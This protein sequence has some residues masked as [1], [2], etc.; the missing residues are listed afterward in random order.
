MSAA[1][2]SGSTMTPGPTPTPTPTP[3]PAPEPVMESTHETPHSENLGMAVGLPISACM[4]LIF[5]A[6]INSKLRNSPVTAIQTKAAGLFEKFAIGGKG[7]LILGLIVLALINGHSS[8]VRDHP[9]QFMQDSFAVAGFGAI[10]AGWLTFTR[11]RSDL[12]M[13]HFVFA[14]MLF[15]L[16][17]VCREFAGYFTVFGTDKMSDQE[18]KQQNVLG[19]PIVIV[20]LIGFVIAIGLAVV[21]HVSPDFSTGILQTF[22][23]T[24]AAF[25][26]E[27]IVF[28]IIVT[29]GELIVA[30][31][32]QE[33]LAAA[34]GMSVALFTF[35]HLVL[36]GG[37]FYEH[38]YSAPPPCIS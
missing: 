2:G 20:G 5:S 9:K 36:Q 32:K 37:G 13:N 6:L 12:F 16:Y 25:I 15:F 34:A 22:A 27:T 24:P 38:L 33:P 23:G 29:A 26:I 3:V 28:V 14:L 31:N 18:K 35:A 21:A 8:Y 4:L 19:L 7:G 30:K 17:H 11:G 10:A 1:E